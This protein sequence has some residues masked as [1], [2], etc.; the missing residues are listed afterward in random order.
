MGNKSSPTPE[1][2]LKQC[3]LSIIVPTPDG[4]YLQELFDSFRSQLEKQDEVIIVG[5]THSRPLEDVREQVL[6]EGFRWLEY[7]A[8]LHAWG[9]PQIN[10]GITQAKGDY[11]V[12]IDDDDTFAHDAFQNIRKAV[13]EAPGRPH[14]FRFVSGRCGTLWKEQT[15]QQACVGGHEFVVPNRPELLGEWSDRYE[16]DYDFIVSTLEKWPKD[17][18]VW[19]EEIISYA[20]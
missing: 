17:S 3:A 11:L 12:F 2:K 8:G 1:A 15:I 5:D 7:D 6:A 19:R 18:L 16:G 14:M 4:G 9:H 20:R 10:Y 13:Q